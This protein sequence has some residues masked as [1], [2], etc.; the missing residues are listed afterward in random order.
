[1]RRCAYIAILFGLSAFLS[2]A[3]EPESSMLPQLFNGWQITRTSVKTGSDPAAVD[4]ADSA[5]LNE[6]GFANSESATYTRNGRNIEV[7]AARFKDSSGAFGAFTFYVQPQM[8]KEDIGARG[9]SNNSRVLFYR[10]NILVEVHLQQVTAMSASDLRALADAL[11]RPKGESSVPPVLPGYLP[12]ESLVVN[13]DRYIE[14]PVALERVGV[15][16]PADLVDFSKGPD[17]EFAKFQTRGG[18]CNLTLVE[19]PT[20]QIAAERL[21]AWQAATLP[22][23]PFYFRRSGPLLEAVS[24][25]VGEGEAQALLASVNYDADV[26]WNQSAHRDR[27]EDR[28]GF[29]IALVLLVVIVLGVAL[30]FGLAFGGLRLWAKK[31]FTKGG[32]DRPDDVEIIR[33]NL[34]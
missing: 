14:G 23:G 26:T 33:L 16:I 9:V 1:M 29:I 3:K 28:Y 21:K 19:Y 22:G 31:L 24:G 5:V 34:K 8:Q 30:I 10:G 11:P 2:W 15:P 18:H 20:P 17:V 4:P 7:K 25:N 32:V 13:T 12:K 6:Y 27:S